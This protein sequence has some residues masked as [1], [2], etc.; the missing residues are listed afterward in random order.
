MSTTSVDRARSIQAGSIQAGFIRAAGGARPVRGLAVATLLAGG[1]AG[2]FTNPA[3]AQVACDPIGSEPIA[4]PFT[5]SAQGFV[6]IYRGVDQPIVGPERLVRYKFY[7]NTG[8]GWVTPLIFRV[9]A[10]DRYEVAAIGQA[11]P[12]IGPGLYDRD[13]IPIVGSNELA[14]DETYTFGFTAR[15]LAPASATQATTTLNAPASIAFTGYNIFT[16]TWSYAAGPGSGT[17]SI[18][19]VYGSGG[20][21]LDSLGFAGR[22]YS[23][24]FFPQ[25]T[26]PGDITGDG[27]L[28]SGDLAAFIDAFLNNQP[29]ADLT[30]DGQIDS[31]DLATFIQLFLAGC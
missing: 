12:I 23:F 8:N 3:A 19:D 4:R 24:E 10:P 26:C 16:D 1:F 31:G 27:R 18:G 30:N 7:S 11:T 6:F 14:A 15:Q 9:T 25:C 20:T 21:P 17:F 5:D 2:G 28:D 29:L 22:I 13:F